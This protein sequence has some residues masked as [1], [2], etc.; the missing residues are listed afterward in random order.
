MPSPNTHTFAPSSLMT[1]YQVGKLLQ[2]NPSSVNKWIKDGRI[3]AYRTP[4]GHRRIRAT[5]LMTFLVAHTMPIPKGLL[6][7]P[8]Q[9][10][11]LA[12]SDDPHFFDLWA[13]GP[14]QKEQALRITLA[15][16][17]LDG[18]L[19][20]GVEAPDVVV[21]GPTRAPLNHLDLCRRLRK[22]QATHKLKIAVVL[23]SG[24]AQSEKEAKLAGADWILT[25]PVQPGALT[26]L[27][28]PAA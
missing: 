7:A 1:S 9:H 27:L 25:G 11:V 22:G 10:S 8:T 14:S 21:L 19:R 26:A 20:V 18:L 17:A 2:V 13:Q 28:T 15:Q 5:D 23:T 24:G 6:V 16:D 12:I 4:G 3:P